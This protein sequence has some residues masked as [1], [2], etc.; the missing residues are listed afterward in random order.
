MNNFF[1]GKIVFYFEKHEK[2]FE[3]TFSPQELCFQKALVPLFLHDLNLPQK[4]L[5]YL[6]KDARS[7]ILKI[8]NI[9]L[10][11][12]KYTC[13][14]LAE[15]MKDAKIMKIQAYGVGSIVALSL[16]FK[17]TITCF[18]CPYTLLPSE[19]KKKVGKK[20]S[21]HFEYTEEF[22]LKPFA[23]LCPQKKKGKRKVAA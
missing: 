8:K 10:D 3:V 5:K 17:T 14:D 22:I 20:S 1:E 12:L 6:T 19:L 9:E 2:T 21:I 11:L 23:S 7:L 13:Q 16:P 4:E 15:E 18:D